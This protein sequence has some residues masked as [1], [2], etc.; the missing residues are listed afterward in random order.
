MDIELRVLYKNEIKLYSILMDDMVVILRTLP[1]PFV[2]MK[3]CERT[4][5]KSHFY[6][7]INHCL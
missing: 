7:I 4:D 1:I 5:E 2:M 3:E 6:S